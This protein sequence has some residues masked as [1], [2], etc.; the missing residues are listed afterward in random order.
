MNVRVVA[1]RLSPGVQYTEE[2]DLCTQMLRVG[3]DGAQRLRRRAE[4][5]VVDHR[6]VLKR[7][8]LDRRRHGE[9]YV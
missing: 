1:K 6:L 2:A 9:H 4:Q 3:S 7:D 5:D 8:D